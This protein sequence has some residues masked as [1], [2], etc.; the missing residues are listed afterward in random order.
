MLF[1]IKHM[2][3]EIKRTYMVIYYSKPSNSIDVTFSH[4]KRFE[5]NLKNETFSQNKAL[6]VIFIPFETRIVNEIVSIHQF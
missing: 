5:L 6:N 4:V 3:F 1:E 2:L